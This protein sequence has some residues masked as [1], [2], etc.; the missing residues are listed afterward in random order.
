MRLA[1][2]FFLILEMRLFIDNEISIPKRVKKKEKGK[3]GKVTQFI[4]LNSL[5]N[6][7]DVVELN[8]I[9]VKY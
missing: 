4:K 8:N 3:R 6:K 7:K 1:F 2:F 5:R 9:D